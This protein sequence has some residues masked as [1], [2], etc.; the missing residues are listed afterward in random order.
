MAKSKNKLFGIMEPPYAVKF[1]GMIAKQNKKYCELI[2]RGIITTS[3]KN[4]Y[5]NLKHVLIIM[6]LIIVQ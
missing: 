5:I 3:F 2:H 4:I 6:L 1:E